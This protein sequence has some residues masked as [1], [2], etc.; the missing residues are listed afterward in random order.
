M[1]LSGLPGLPVFETVSEQA[2]LTRRWITWK[3][4]FELYV[5]ASGIS[6][7]TQ[8]RA[9]LLHLAGPRVQDIFSNS[10]PADIR[11]GAMEYAKVIDILSEINKK[12]LL[13]QQ[14]L[15]QTVSLL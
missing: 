4:E 7:P 12:S 3:A 14:H 1:C 9:P 2:T 5:I 8:K 13:K 6:D 15:Q 10:I 11:G